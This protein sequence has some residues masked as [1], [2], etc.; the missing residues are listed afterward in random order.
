MDTEKKETLDPSTWEIVQRE[1]FAPLGRIAVTFD[2]GRTCSMQLSSAARDTLGNPA[3][4][5]L[6]IN[7]K[8][9]QMLLMGTN[10]KRPNCFIIHAPGKRDESDPISCEGLINRLCELMGWKP[11]R[12]YTVVGS[13]MPGSMLA[14]DLRMSLLEGGNQNEWSEHFGLGGSPAQLLQGEHHAV[15]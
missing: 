15:V 3:Y 1:S 11:G 4:G 6:L 14:F 2:T 8:T 12:R 7:P 13:K 9:Q 10:Q 5:Q